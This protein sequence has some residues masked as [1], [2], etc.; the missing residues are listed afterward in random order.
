MTNV[1][2]TIHANVVTEGIEVDSDEYYNE[3]NSRL[4]KYFPASF[5]D[6]LN[7]SQNKSKGNPSKPLLRLVDN[8]RDAEL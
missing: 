8:K 5:A 2:Q 1:A 7:N 4:R 3:I 6:K